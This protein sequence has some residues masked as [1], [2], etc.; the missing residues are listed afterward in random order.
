MAQ[1]RVEV[2][3]VHAP[4]EGLV[5]EAPPAER[6]DVEAGEPLRGRAR[7]RFPAGAVE[8]SLELVVT[9]AEGDA[10]ARGALDESLGDGRARP[11]RLVAQDLVAE[12]DLAPAEEAQAPAGDGVGEQLPGARLAG[13]VG[14]EEDEPDGEV[15][16][17]HAAEAAGLQLGPQ[18]VVRDLRRDSGSVPGAPVRVHRAPVGEPVERGQGEGEQSRRRPSLHLGEEADPTSVV[19]KLGGALIELHGHPVSGA[20]CYKRSSKIA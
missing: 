15:P 8:R 1:V 18:H 19:M 13:G 9:E 6:R 11:A 3:E 2:G 10:R 7:L 20:L 16:R 14:R 5:D 12:G 4:H 17:R